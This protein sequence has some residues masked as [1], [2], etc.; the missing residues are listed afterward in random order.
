MRLSVILMLV[1]LAVAT[2]L[3]LRVDRGFFLND[4]V[5]LVL[6]GALLGGMIAFERSERRRL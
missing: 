6:F 2:T 5:A 1:Y 4:A 3:A